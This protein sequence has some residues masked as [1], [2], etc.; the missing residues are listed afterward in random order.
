MFSNS[1]I[2][3]LNKAFSP[4]SQVV[5]QNEDLPLGEDSSQMSSQVE[6]ASSHSSQTQ[7]TVV[8]QQCKMKRQRFTSEQVSQSQIGGGKNFR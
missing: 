1:E 8:I 6:R 4:A 7:G 3:N 2:N 5:V